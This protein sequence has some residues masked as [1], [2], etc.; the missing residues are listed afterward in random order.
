[1]T[2]Q[3]ERNMVAEI[4]RNV[5]DSVEHYGDKPF[6]EKT[7]RDIYDLFIAMKFIDDMSS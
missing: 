7:T 5:A 4:L 3:S 1:M 2:T 6:K